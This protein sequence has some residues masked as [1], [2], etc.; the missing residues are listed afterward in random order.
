MSKDRSKIIVK[1]GWLFILTN[2]LLA[3]LNVM[4]GLISNSLAIISDAL[5]SLIDSISGFLV[6]ISEKFANHKKFK[7]R[8]EKIERVTTVIIA[9]IIIAV[10]VHIVVE[11]IEKIF[12]PEEVDYSWPVMIILV[13]SIAIKWVLAVY[14]KHRG[15][16]H[17]SSVLLASGAETM[18][19]MLISV[20]VLASAV[21]YLIWQVNIEAYVSILIALV[22]FK[23]GLEFI[24]PHLSKHHHHH[25]ES[26]SDHDHCRK[27]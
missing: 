20:A 18:N 27:K 16:E 12:E 2:F 22:I 19:D 15:K 10:G 8:R 21:I 26:D 4:I 9:L 6:V 17:K 13:L 5:H 3:G 1:C 23:I 25:L 24:F 11:S 14:L 7:A